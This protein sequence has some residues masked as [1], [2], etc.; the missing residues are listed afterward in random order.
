MGGACPVS[1]I[2]FSSPPTDSGRYSL[3]DLFNKCGRRFSLKTVL[4]L[5]DQV[6]ERVETMHN[7]HLIHRD[8]KPA[9]FVIGY[10]NTS[11]VHC[12]DFGLSKRY[13]HPRTLQHIPYRDGRSLTGTPRY[14]SINNH[15]GVE[16]SRRDDLESIGY[17]LVYFLRGVLP[18]QGLKAKTASKKYKMIMEKKQSVSIAELCQGCPVQ[19]AEYLT[20]CRQLSFDMKPDMA[21]L[22]GLFR[23]LYIQQGYASSG[24]E[25]DWDR[26]ITPYGGLGEEAPKPPPVPTSRLLTA[27]ARAGADAMDTTDRLGLSGGGGVPDSRDRD[28]A[29]MVLSES[30]HKSQQAMQPSPVQA[31]AQPPQSQPAMADSSAVSPAPACT[32]MMALS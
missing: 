15:L 13:R 12:I 28:R 21:Y 5:A 16:Q 24:V 25:W 7:R 27:S 2:P 31:Q 17:V 29:D 32:H 22:K 4:Q 8:I 26:F 1:P 14:A 9:N 19:F 30:R 20:Y 23:E 10:H 6:L 11:V 18:W 3:E